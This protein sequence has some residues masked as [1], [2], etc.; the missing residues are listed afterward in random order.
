MGLAARLAGRGLGL[1]AGFGCAVVMLAAWREPAIPMSLRVFAMSLAVVSVIRPSIGLTVLAGFL[2]MA[3]PLQAYAAAR[4]P[5]AAVGELLVLAFLAGAVPRLAFARSAPSPLRWPALVLGALVAAGGVVSMAATQQT[6][7]SVSA[8]LDAIW[9]HVSTAYFVDSHDFGDLHLAFMWIESLMLAV[10]ADRVARLDPPGGRAAVRMA[11]VGAAAVAAFSVNRLSE[12]WSRSLEPMAAVMRVVRTIRFNPFYTDINAAGSLY[13]LF[14]VPAIWLATIGRQYLFALAVFLLGAAAWLA[15]SRAALLGV[16]LGLVIAWVASI[17]V[18][19]TRRTVV[20]TSAVILVAT[21]ILIPVMRMRGSSTVADAVSI[22]KDMTSISF[23]V[24]AIEPVFGVGLGRFRTST[25]AFISPDA[26]KRFPTLV[27]GENAHNN[28]LQLLGEL[29][30]MALVAFVWML[31]VPFRTSW[32][33]RQLGG[34]PSVQFGIAGG[35]AAFAISAVAGHPLLNDHLR[36]CFFLAV[37]LAAGVDAPAAPP[38]TSMSRRERVIAGVVCV[39]LAIIAVTLPSRMGERRRAMSLDAV[40]IGASEERKAPEGVFYRVA[41]PHAVFHVPAWA[42]AA[43]VPL[44]ADPGSTAPCQIQVSVD[45]APAD[46]VTA[47]G[48]R[49]QSVPVPVTAPTARRSRR[50]ELSSPAGCRLM[51][52]RF[53]VHH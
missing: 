3:F 4:I 33:I 27:F 41:E 49:W 29:G 47:P 19:L 17:R 36:L 13:A 25:V 32:N 8:Y 34:S 26:I 1:I 22:R 21:A 53:V 42:K 40:V 20:T 45:G 2:P 46:A 14:L 11:V 15:G 43:E 48:D 10:A 7:L 24:A 38:A 39:L 28:F 50:I 35:I 37:G 30:P 6:S 16:V 23:Q 12:I 31:V 5:G 9:R 52:G 18:V 51:V 44:R